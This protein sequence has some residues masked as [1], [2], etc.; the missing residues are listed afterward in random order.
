MK[1]FFKYDF[2]RYNFEICISKLW[3]VTKVT[4]SMIYSIIYIGVKAICTCKSSLASIPQAESF[5][6]FYWKSVTKAFCSSFFSEMK[7]AKVNP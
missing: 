2:Q 5:Y 1:Y 3:N 4:E 7:K 6:F